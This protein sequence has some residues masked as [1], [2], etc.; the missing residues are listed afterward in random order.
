M[1]GPPP[2]SK[3]SRANLVVVKQ[4]WKAV[5][6]LMIGVGTWVWSYEV[7][8]LGASDGSCSASDGSFSR[9]PPNYIH[10]LGAKQNNLNTQRPVTHRHVYNENFTR[11]TQAHEE[12][13]FYSSTLL[14]CHVPAPLFSCKS[15]KL[16]FLFG[17]AKRKSSQWIS[18][19]LGSKQKDTYIFVYIY[20]FW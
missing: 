18:L 17:E 12:S 7:I 3:P 8:Q 6:F 20:L 10:T 5:I 2:R 19:C 13:L 9:G 15:Y 11:Y 16:C 14:E 1:G 4:P